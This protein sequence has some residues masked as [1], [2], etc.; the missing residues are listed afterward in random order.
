MK[1][2]KQRFILKTIME[3]YWWK[4]SRYF[5]DAVGAVDAITASNNDEKLV[6]T[7]TVYFAKL[8]S[9]SRFER[10]NKLDRDD[11]YCT[12]SLVCTPPPPLHH[13]NT[14]WHCFYPINAKARA[15]MAGIVNK[16]YSQKVF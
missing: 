2:K 9:L 8:N 4:W 11:L 7:R 16:V 10:I 5:F 1:K 14:M 13:W 3:S 6:E 12:L 15:K